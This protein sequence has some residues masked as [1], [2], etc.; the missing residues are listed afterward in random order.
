MKTVFTNGCFDLLHPGHVDL[1]E[2]ARALGDRLVV[3]LNSD[4]SVRSLKGPQKPYVNEHD[5]RRMLLALRAVDAVI[6]FDELD[7]LRLICELGPDVLVKGGDWPVEK[8]V[9]ADFVLRRGGSVHSLN[10]L[11]GYSTTLVVEQIRQPTPAATWRKA[12]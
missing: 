8:I 3:G 2:R 1:L 11:P 6:I 12:S 4:A 10:L 7:P 9:G 5:R